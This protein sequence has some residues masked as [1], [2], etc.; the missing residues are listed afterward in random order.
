MVNEEDWRLQRAD[1][2]I[3]GTAFRRK[4]YRAPSPKW[5]HDHCAACWAKFAEYEGPEYLHEGFA[6][7]A[8]YPKGE[9]YEWVC[10]ECFEE[11][12]DQMSWVSVT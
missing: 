6:V 11:L 7:T 10:P 3:P 9:D 8:D 12:K 2:F 1:R 4:P 5:D